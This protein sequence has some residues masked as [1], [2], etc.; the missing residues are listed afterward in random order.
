MLGQ[1]KCVLLRR[2]HT[3]RDNVL[4]ETFAYA[5]HGTNDDGVIW[6]ANHIAHERLVNLQGI[7]RKLF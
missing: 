6:V 2:F 4:I 5:D 7:D 3:L 1:E